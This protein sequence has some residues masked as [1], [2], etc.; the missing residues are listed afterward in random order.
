MQETEYIWINGNLVKWHEAK[1]HVLTHALHYGSGVFEGIRAYDTGKGTAVFRLKDHLNRL[2]DSAESLKMKIPYS[3]E[4][5]RKAIKET[6]KINNLKEGYVRPI[7]F[8]GYGK[9]GLN[10]EG[11]EINIAIS[12]WPWPQYIEGEAKVMISSY[13][14]IHPQSL[15]ADRKVTGHYV[16]SI[17]A[18]I[19]AKEKDFDESLLLDYE[20]NVAEGPGENI[21]VVKNNK[22]LTP[23]LRKQI[24]PGITRDSVIKIAKGLH[25]DVLEK[26]ISVKE[27]KNADELFFTGTAA[28]IAPIS[29][30]DEVFFKNHEITNKIKDSFKEIIKGKNPRYE[31]W[32]DFV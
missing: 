10:P 32:L 6:L 22:I 13:I 17:L 21:F 12:V 20:G 30:L 16:N 3:R 8:Y 19:E 29:Q 2:F 18:S 7:V 23:P 28:E 1:I 24:L 31:E 9:M 26:D 15:H 25:Y 4:E 14:R 27:L 5:I 11:A